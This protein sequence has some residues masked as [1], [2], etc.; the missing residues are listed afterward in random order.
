M[1]FGFFV[2]LPQLWADVLNFFSFSKYC[3]SFR[4]ECQNLC[5]IILSSDGE[6][7]HLTFVFVFF[8]KSSAVRAKDDNLCLGVLFSQ[9][10]HWCRITAWQNRKWL[11]FLVSCSDGE[12]GCLLAIPLPLPELYCCSCPISSLFP[13]FV[14]VD[15]AH[16]ERS[17]VVF[18]KINM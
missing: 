12:Q 18:W 15:L 7:W 10:D 8:L 3:K 14:L 16:R 13:V 5:G 11:Y 1:V 6:L 17:M 4:Y 2:Y 9:S